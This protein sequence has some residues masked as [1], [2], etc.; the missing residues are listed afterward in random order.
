MLVPEAIIYNNLPGDL[1]L[2]FASRNVSVLSEKDSKQGDNVKPLN[3]IINLSLH[4]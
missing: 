4:S 1:F 2:S 3:G